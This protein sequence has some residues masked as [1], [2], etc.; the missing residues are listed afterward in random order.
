[1]D[2]EGDEMQIQVIKKIMSQRV[3][4]HFVGIVIFLNEYVI[5]FSA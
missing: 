1:M 2:K 5:L 3:K 4:N